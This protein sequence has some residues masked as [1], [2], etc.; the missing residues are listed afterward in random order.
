MIEL[1]ELQQ[2][3]M[4]QENDLP[5]ALNPRTN[6]TY[7]LIPERL[8]HRLRTVFD[9]ALAPQQVGLLVAETMRDYDADD[10]LL[11]SY[12]KYRP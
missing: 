10:P 1:T 3:A 6:Q 2:Q 8:Y 5:R 7:V 4:E 11:D 12:E 9:E